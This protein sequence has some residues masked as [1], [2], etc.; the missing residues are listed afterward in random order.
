MVTN[1]FPLVSEA[2]KQA[3]VAAILQ[4]QTIAEK[5]TSKRISE[6]EDQR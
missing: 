5:E 6:L 2:E 1:G 3:Q 4:K